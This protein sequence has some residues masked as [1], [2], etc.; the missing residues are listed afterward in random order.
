MS[1]PN[2]VGWVGTFLIVLA[3]YLISSKKVTGNS[4]NYQLLNFFGALG[5]IVNTYTQKAWPAMTLNIIWAFIA[6]KTLT[7]DKKSVN[8]EE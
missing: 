5:I 1:L 4:R 6:I 8:D 7:Y 2:I 3:Y